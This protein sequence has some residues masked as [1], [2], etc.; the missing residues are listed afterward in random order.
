MA[1]RK[2]DDSDRAI[3]LSR[4]L[5]DHDPADPALFVAA[6]THGSHASTNKGEA[7]YE[8]L[9]FLGDRVLGLVVADWLYARF[10]QEEEGKIARRYNALV[11]RE[12]CAEV[13]RTLGLPDHI[14]L[15]RQARDDKAQQSDNVIGDV[16]EALIGALYLE[17]GMKKCE[18]FVQTHWAPWLDEQRKAPIH[19]KS[20]LQELAA[21]KKLGAPA[22]EKTGTKG[23]PHNPRFTVRVTVRHFSAEAEGSSKQEAE[24][25]AAKALLKEL[26]IS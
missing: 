12:T 17:A 21:A 2:P 6:L 22:Y 13:G 25:E 11:A 16:V 10:P 8:R 18:R 5:F 26:K 3:A 4:D 7:S 14:R 15:G 24:T 9:E 1:N 19:P 20:A 23:P